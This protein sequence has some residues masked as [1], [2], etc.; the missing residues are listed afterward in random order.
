[1]EGIS[2]TLK[3]LEGSWFGVHIRSGLARFH[4]GFSSLLYVEIVETLHRVL[5]PF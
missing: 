5:G 4:M 3:T 1:M 2:G